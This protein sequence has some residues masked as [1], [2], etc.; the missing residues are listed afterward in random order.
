M[1]FDFGGVCE[2]D[3]VRLFFFFMCVGMYSCWAY[4]IGVY[5]I[6]NYSYDKL[7]KNIAKQARHKKKIDKKQKKELTA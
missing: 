1:R 2:M 3:F 6:K 7:Y 5:R 4:K